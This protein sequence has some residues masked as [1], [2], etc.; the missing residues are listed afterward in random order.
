MPKPLIHLNFGLLRARSYWY[1][2]LI[3]AFQIIGKKWFAI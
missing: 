1:A 2:D 3:F